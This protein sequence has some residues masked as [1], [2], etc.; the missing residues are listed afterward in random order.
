[1]LKYTLLISL[2]FSGWLTYAGPSSPSVGD[3]VELYIYTKAQDT[4]SDSYTSWEIGN[5]NPDDFSFR[6]DIL[7]DKKSSE[8]TRVTYLT[9]LDELLENYYWDPI[10]DCDMM[11]GVVEIITVPAGV[12]TACKVQQDG[13][14]LSLTAWLGQV[15]FLRIKEVQVDKV[16]GITVTTVLSDYN[17]GE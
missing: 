16:K 6:L 13:Y 5:Y 10:A 4:E 2:L 17:W 11:E 15:P 12:F 7:N 3:Y 9:Y 1:M 14:D 8:A